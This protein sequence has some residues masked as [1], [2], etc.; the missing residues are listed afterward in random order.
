MA[1]AAVARRQRARGLSERLMRGGGCAAGACGACGGQWELSQRSI[2]LLRVLEALR[3]P[4]PHSAAAGYGYADAADAARGEVSY[5]ERA[6]GWGVLYT[7]NSWAPMVLAD[8]PHGSS[9][10]VQVDPIHSG[11]RPLW[12]ICSAGLCARPALRPAHAVLVRPPAHSLRGDGPARAPASRPGPRACKRAS[13]T[14][15]CN[16]SPQAPSRSQWRCTRAAAACF[17]PPRLRGAKARLARQAVAERLEQLSRRLSSW[18]GGGGGGAGLLERID[19]L[20]AGGAGAGWKR[21]GAYGGVGE[22]DVDDEVVQRMEAYL[23]HR[24]KGPAARSPVVADS[25]PD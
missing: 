10:G 14:G 9:N 20:A 8:T 1:A 12:I 5:R 25:L 6:A 17:G 7:K 22:G 24:H 16:S 11:C 18:S 13:L 21:G 2:E 4:S 19:A 15:R 3:R 23:A